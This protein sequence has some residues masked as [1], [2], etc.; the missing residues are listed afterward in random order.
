MAKSLTFQGETMCFAA[1]AERTGINWLTIYKRIKRG[2]SVE[3]SLTT[4]QNNPVRYA[5]MTSC[6][7]IGFRGETLTLSQWARRLGIT[8]QAL[9]SRIKNKGVESALGR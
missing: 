2:W 1:W 5:T 3:Q 9:A 7:R 4:P 8:K 6:R